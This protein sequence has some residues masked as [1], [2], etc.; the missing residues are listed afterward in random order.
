MEIKYHLIRGARI[1]VQLEETLLE[2]ST[3]NDLERNV[4]NYNPTSKKR[5]NAVD[6]VRITK[7]ETLPAIG[8]KTLSVWALANSTDSKSGSNTVYEPSIIF[9]NVEFVGG[10][11]QQGEE[12]E[13]VQQQ[14]QSGTITAKARDGRDYS[15]KVIDLAKNNVRVNC[16][17]LDFYWR[18]RDTNAKDKSGVLRSK[19]AYQPKTDRVSVNPQQVPGLC[20]HLLATFRALKHS[21]MVR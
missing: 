6:P 5:Q 4:I 16:Q 8:M 21:G 17:C 1:V 2:K 18:F 3:Y 13:E 7:L 19:P 10:E 12:Q 9:N 20:K 11:E 15:M 14:D